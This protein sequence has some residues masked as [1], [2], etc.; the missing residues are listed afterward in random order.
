MTESTNGSTGPVFEQKDNWVSFT[1]NSAPGYDRIGATV[2]GEPGFVAKVFAVKD[3]NG[4]VS[5]LMK[6]A[7]EIDKYFKKQYGETAT[8]G[9]D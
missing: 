6:Q 5:S 1:F 4:K 3:F 8:P 7:V 2:H 9:K